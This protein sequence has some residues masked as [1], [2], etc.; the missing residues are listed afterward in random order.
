MSGSA[1]VAVGAYSSCA[2]PVGV[3]GV[4]EGTLTNSATQQ[5]TPV[6]AIIDENGDGSM[7]GQDGTYYRLNVAQAANNVSGSFHGYS[8]AADFPNGSQSD[9]GSI[10]AAITQPGLSGTLTDQAGN[11]ETLSLNFDNVYTLSSS[12][13]TLAGT[14][15]MSANGLNLTATIQTD[16]TFSA[17]DSNSCSYSGA[18]G[19]IDVNFNA[20]SVYYVRSCNGTSL[21]FSGLASYFPAAGSTTPAQ[22]KVLADDSVGDYLVADFQ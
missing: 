2:A 15:S 19:L 22:I 20:Y 4:Y 12:L 3:D 17:V 16:G 8:Q 1:P 13:P 11:T 10:A 21:T 6:I 18:F 9:T 7:A 14:W 5:E